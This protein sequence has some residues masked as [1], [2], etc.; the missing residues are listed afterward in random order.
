VCG[1]RTP[2]TPHQ[3]HFLDVF[4]AEASTASVLSA[5]EPLSRQL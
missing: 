1:G 3:L 4:E 5:G 2:N